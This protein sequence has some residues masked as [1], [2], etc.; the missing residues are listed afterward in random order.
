MGR[1]ILCWL[2]SILVEVF[3]DCLNS[4]CWK[5]YY[6]IN[7]SLSQITVSKLL[8]LLLLYLKINWWDWNELPDSWRCFLRLLSGKEGLQDRSRSFCCR[9]GQ[10]GIIVCREQ[11][12]VSPA[13]LSLAA[14]AKVSIFSERSISWSE[15][16][17]LS[18]CKLTRRC[19]SGSST[20]LLQV[21]V[22]CDFGQKLQR[23]LMSCVQ[24]LND[25]TFS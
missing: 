24:F 25:D 9:K 19:S 15:N 16:V 4:G 1:Y 10:K 7:A 21:A 2:D 17:L 12:K 14:N 8:T 3:R 23:Y 18:H 20:L 22:S 13:D 6:L 11:R 5:G